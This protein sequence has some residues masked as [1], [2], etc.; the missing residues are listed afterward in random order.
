MKKIFAALLA[1]LILVMPVLAC[2]EADPLTEALT[3]GRAL[4]TSLSFKANDESL[5][6]LDSLALSSRFQ[7]YPLLA[8][9]EIDY[10]TKDLSDFDFSYNEDSD[11]FYFKSAALG[12]MIGISSQDLINMAEQILEALSTSDVVSEMEAE[13]AIER[14]DEVQFETEQFT[15][16]FSELD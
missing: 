12:K 16:D 15:L 14:A 7:L 6:A 2:A 13:A 4:N 11:S 10:D 5:A 1:M 3:N 8:H 9:F